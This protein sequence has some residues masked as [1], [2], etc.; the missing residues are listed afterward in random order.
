MPPIAECELVVAGWLSQDNEYQNVSIHVMNRKLRP[1]GL[2]K[3]VLGWHSCRQ[4]I[5][6][7]NKI[8]IKILIHLIFH[9]A[10]Q[11]KRNIS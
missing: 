5:K 1:R 8:G 3:K 7:D 2:E 11:T 9:S 6:K 4:T 10:T